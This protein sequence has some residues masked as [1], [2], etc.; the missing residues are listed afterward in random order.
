[1]RVL[2]IAILITVTMGCSDRFRFKTAIRKFAK[3]NKPALTGV[4]KYSQNY[5]CL[6]RK[7]DF[8]SLL[9]KSDSLYILLTYGS[10]YSKFATAIYAKEWT[11][12]YWSDFYRDS[13]V[14]NFEENFETD[15][16][17]QI[18]LSRM[19][20]TKLNKAENNAFIAQSKYTVLLLVTVKSNGK[21][22]RQIL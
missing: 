2:M 6:Y 13:F 21:L 18:M 20:S 15:R 16:L 12:H 14:T 7:I 3:S 5:Y 9:K 19:D 4:F 10:H 1:M 11:F 17:L 22:K 8:D